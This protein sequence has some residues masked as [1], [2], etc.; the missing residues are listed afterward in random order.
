LSKEWERKHADENA[1]LGDKLFAKGA[2]IE[3]KKEKLRQELSIDRNCT[4][5]PQLAKKT[6]K[7]LRESSGAR[8][9]SKSTTSLAQEDR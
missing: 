5:K 2:E 7:I 3:T 8:Q 4:F 1:P 9:G 6:D